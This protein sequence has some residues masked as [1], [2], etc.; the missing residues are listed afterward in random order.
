[1][2]I[3]YALRRLWRGVAERGKGVSIKISRGANGKRTKNIT[4]KHFPGRATEKRPKI[5]TISQI[6]RPSY[7]S[8]INIQGVLS[9]NLNFAKKREGKPY[10]NTVATNNSKH[11]K[12]HKGTRDPIAIR[13]RAAYLSSVIAIMSL[14]AK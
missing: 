3:D 2:D 1:M 10:S 12:E 5:A 9:Q 13:V 8:C 6:C 14:E 7:V 4:I 11:R